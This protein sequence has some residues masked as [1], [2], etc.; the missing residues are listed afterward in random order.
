MLRP[1]YRLLIY[2]TIQSL[3]Y[4]LL[5]GVLEKIRGENRQS[6]ILFAYR[7]REDETVKRILSELNGVPLEELRYDDSEKALGTTW[8]AA[9][10]D[11]NN[12]LRPNDLG[13]LVE[14]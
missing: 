11:I 5:E 6:R 4:G 1:G 2:L 12:Q 3:G 7:E 9:V 10:L 13:L 14:L 8:D